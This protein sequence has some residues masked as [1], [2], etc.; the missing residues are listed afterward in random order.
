MSTRFATAFQSISSSVRQISVL[1]PAAILNIGVLLYICLIYGLG[2]ALLVQDA[3]ATNAVGLVL[4]VH[5][6]VLSAAMTHELIHDNIFKQRSL[7]RF[8]GQVMTHINGACYAPYE[9]LVQHHFNHHIYHADFVPFESAKFFDRLPSFVRR[10]CFALEWA[11]FPVFEFILRWRLIV[12]PFINPQKSSRC[13]RTL[14]LLLYRGICFTVL[15]W[16]SLRALGLY[17]LA[18]ICFVNLMRFADAFHHTYDYVVMGT[19]IPKRDRQYEQAHTFSNL[20]SVR[21]PWLNLLYLNFGYHN[22]HHH[23]MRCP[24]YR[25]PDLHHRLYGEESK[26]LLPLPWLVMNYHGFRLK[27][28]VGGQGASPQNQTEGFLSGFTGGIGVSFLTPP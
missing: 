27:R 18:Y 14:V 15:G 16:I 13:G 7:N 19:D 3:W 22:A 9:D 28:L 4:V 12:A 8:W 2:I 10:I 20:V 26:C 17:A 5:G 21:Y 24:W 11:Y 25:L 6:L 23:D 1:N